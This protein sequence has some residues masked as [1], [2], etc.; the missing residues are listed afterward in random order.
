MTF[1][2]EEDHIDVSRLRAHHPVAVEA[3]PHHREKLF[4]RL[5]LGDAALF[6]PTQH[7]FDPG[8]FRSMHVTLPNRLR[9]V[10]RL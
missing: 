10:R 3:L 2:R 5:G 1:V 9:R 4:D 6:I 8:P 7:V